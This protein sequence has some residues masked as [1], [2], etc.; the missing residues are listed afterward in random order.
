MK[1]LVVLILNILILGIIYGQSIN[2]MIYQNWVEN[3]WQN[4]FKLNHIYDENGYQISVLEE[5]YEINSNSWKNSAL[6]IYINNSNGTIQEYVIKM[7]NSLTNSWENYSKVV[8]TYIGNNVHTITHQDWIA[9]NWNNY[10]KGTYNYDGHGYTISSLQESYDINS[11]SWKNVILINYTNNSNG[12]IQEYVSQ[13]W[14][15][16]TSSWKNA[17]KAIYTYIGNN[18]NAIIYQ[19]WV[20]NNWQ[21]SSKRSYTYDGNDYLINDLQ[22]AWINSNSWKN[23]SLTNYTNNSN[24]TVQEYIYKNWDNPTSSWENAARAIYTYTMSLTTTINIIVL[25]NPVNGGAVSGSGAYE[26][27]NNVTVSA[28][29]NANYKF[30]NWT[31]NGAIVSTNNPYSFTATEDVTLVANFELK[32]GIADIVQETSGLILSPNPVETY[33][34]ILGK[35]LQNGTLITISDIL[36][37]NIANIPVNNNTINVGALPNGLYFIKFENFVGKFLKN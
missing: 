12:T 35:E 34:T 22:E 1:K 3:N 19:G 11:N 15:S 29:P 16:P 8:Y 24:G 10:I 4:Y 32:T 2:T 18:I 36:G 9:N 28:T 5:S 25:T 7:W 20:V 27:G 13:T 17:S 37:K 6:T 33:L 31:K 30:V 23:L 14:D 26:N 21:N